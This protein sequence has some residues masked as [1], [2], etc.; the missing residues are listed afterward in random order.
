[1]ANKKATAPATY[2]YDDL[3]RR[4]SL[5]GHL[6]RSESAPI[7]EVGAPW[8]S[9]VLSPNTPVHFRTRAAAILANKLQCRRDF[10]EQLQDPAAAQAA[11]TLRHSTEPLWIGILLVA[12]DRKRRDLDNL[13]ARL[14]STLDSLADCL[15]INDHRFRVI[16]AR[17][18]QATHPG[19]IVRIAVSQATH[20]DS[21]TPES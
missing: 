9:K 6:S 14:K 18:A 4:V 19:G 10:L 5:I 11:H 15:G 2:R 3:V 7:L 17:L 1:M 20:D 12:P 21:A 8:P 16:C 13:V